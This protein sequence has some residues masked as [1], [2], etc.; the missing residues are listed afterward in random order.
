MKLTERRRYRLGRRGEAAAETRR[1]VVQATFD[2]HAEQGIRDTTMQQI[3]ARAGV[4][5]GT[6]Y[7]HF[8]TY[9]DAIA[10]CGDHAARSVPPPDAAIFDGAASRRDRVDRLVRALFDF[11]RRLPALAS[12]RR[13]R[14]LAPTLAAFADAE[15]ALRHRLSALAAG[16]PAA[17]AKT[18]GLAAL[19]DLDVAA[20]FARAG[21][22]TEAAAAQVA[23]IANAWLDSEE[24]MTT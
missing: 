23:A 5:I 7:H 8:P 16:R 4:S 24:G 21:Y 1:R 6:V 12:V 14:D 17:A 9:A 13:D 22:G 19:V 11:Y 3:A 15:A 20:A 2:L 18:R 10:A